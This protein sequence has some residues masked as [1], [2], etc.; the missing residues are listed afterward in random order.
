MNINWKP[1]FSNMILKRGENY[2]QEGKVLA[3]RGNKGRD[4][5][6]FYVYGT[7]AYVVKITRGDASIK[8]MQCDC[9]HA[10]DG[11]RC[12]HM[13][14]AL[15]KMEADGDL[16]IRATKKTNNPAKATG[17]TQNAKKAQPVRVFPFRTE[18]AGE[19]GETPYQFYNLDQATASYTIWISEMRKP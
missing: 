7:S 13:A 6:V 15:F 16:K 17:K 10:Q 3:Q 11:N 1:L 19:K 12:K 18:H 9:P 14:A 8:S 4:T 2:F 5:K